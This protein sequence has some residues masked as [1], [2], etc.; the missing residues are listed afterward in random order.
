MPDVPSPFGGSSCEPKLKTV[1]GKLGR[2]KRATKL[3]GPQD[4]EFDAGQS[5]WADSNT[6]STKSNKSIDISANERFMTHDL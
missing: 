1:E 2:A 5:A 4:S 3:P 6:L